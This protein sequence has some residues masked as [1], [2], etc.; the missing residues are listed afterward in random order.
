[1]MRLFS[2]HVEN[3]NSKLNH[4]PHV[5]HYLISNRHFCL[6][7]FT[8]N[9]GQCLQT[10]SFCLLVINNTLVLSVFKARSKVIQCVIIG[11]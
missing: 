2:L 5:P 3:Y 1:M 6:D 11:I 4:N 10:E 8:L 9:K 7:H